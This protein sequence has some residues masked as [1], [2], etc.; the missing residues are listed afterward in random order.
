MEVSDGRDY[1]LHDGPGF[2]F[3]EEFLPDDFIEKFS[4]PHQ[5]KHEV[6]VLLLFERVTKGDD[7]GVVSVPKQNLDLVSAVSLGLV[8]D[9][10]GVLL[11]RRAM[12]ATVADRITSVPDLGKML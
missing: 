2:A 1:L 6:D 7:V 8:D 9:L 5:I 11:T 10:D 12:D 3:G 4:A